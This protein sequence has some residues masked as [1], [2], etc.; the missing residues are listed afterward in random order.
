MDYTI[1]TIAPIILLPFFAFVINVFIVKKAT[2]LSAA[3][4]S[5]N[6]T[7]SKTATTF[8][9]EIIIMSPQTNKKALIN[10]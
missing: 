6:S 2:K 9:L 4:L 10:R 8:F 1:A 5:K 7:P 3:A